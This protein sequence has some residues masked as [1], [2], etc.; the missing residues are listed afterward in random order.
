MPQPTFS[1]L[2]DN[3]TTLIDGAVWNGAAK[4]L[5]IT[6]AQVVTPVQ[7]FG[8]I[9]QS[10]QQWLVT[11]EDQAVNLAASTPTR[12]TSSRNGQI[13]DQINLSVQVYTPAASIE[14][15]PLSL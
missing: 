1:E 15:D 5:T 9:I 3:T 14:Y 6:F 13:K 10:G 12:N 8:A 7:A 2:F 11:N 4:T